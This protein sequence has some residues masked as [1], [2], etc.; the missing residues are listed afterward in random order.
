MMAKCVGASAGIAG[1]HTFIGSVLAFSC[2]AL[3]VT[4]SPTVR[5]LVFLPL[6]VTRQF[7][8]VL[9]SVYETLCSALQ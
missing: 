6:P 3:I 1:M 7:V 5:K 4:V 8:Y 2:E 9:M